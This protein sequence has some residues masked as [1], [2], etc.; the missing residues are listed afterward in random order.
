MMMKSVTEYLEKTCKKYPKKIAF[1]D[2]KRQITFSELCKEAKSIATVIAENNVFKRPVAVF[3]DKSVEC[4][5]AFM[6]IAYS[7]NFYTPIDSKMPQERVNKIFT[8]LM[9]EY[10]VTDRVHL[11][12]VKTIYDDSRILVY[13]DL[14]KVE[15][16]EKLVNKTVRMIV[17]TDVL[18]VLF[19][20]GSTGIPKGV[21]ISHRSVIDYT[22][23]V[24]DYFD[25]DEAHIFGNQAP[26]YFDNSVLDIYQTLK[27]G[28][29]MFI[30]PE[31][32]FIFPIK[33]LEYISKN[34]INII[35]WVPSLLCLVANLKALG[36]VEI[37]C[38]RK[39]LFAGEVMP[40]KQLNMWIKALPE[41]LYANLYGPTEITDVC[42]AYIVDRE[43]KDTDVLPIGKACRNTD[44]LIL[45]D[46]NELVKYGEIGEL[47][48]RG[49]SLALGYYNNLEKTKEVFVQNPLNSY[50]PEIIYRT[51]DL[52]KYNDF[53]EI[54]YVS[55]KDFQIKHLGHRIELGEIETAVSSVR[56]VEVSCCV[57]D[58]N[59]NRIVLYYVG[60]CTDEEV[61]CALK[62]LVPDYMIPNLIT[63]LES[64]PT[65]LNGKIDRQKL[66]EFL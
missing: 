64:M 35:F 24:T 38:L 36:K 57:Y 26:F 18:Y 4:I 20:S 15:P 42:T 62:M 61:I 11:D 30:I 60:E 43:F 59:K 3:L 16:N 6:G 45:N 55:R 63:K 37:K 17:D 5:V 29:T 19:T 50:Y 51:G 13:E 8:T 58:G 31:N 23:W 49:S 41:A 40:V 54:E 56:G 66:K 28:A 10:V 25:I 32:L 2:C 34:N 21:V 65:N 14:V 47:C 27:N 33:L 39:I 9:P 53:G 22:E 7:G 52:V 12:Y 48:V 46:R 1:A 44:I